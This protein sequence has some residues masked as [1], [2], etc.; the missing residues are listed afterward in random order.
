MGIYVT[1]DGGET[2]K[3][4]GAL[5]HSVYQIEEHPSDPERLAAACG[6]GG[7]FYT[8]NVG[9]WWE[10]ENSGMPENYDIRNIAI[11]DVEPQ[12]NRL[13]VYANSYG[14]G[15]FRSD[16][17]MSLE[18]PGNTRTGLSINS[19]YPNPAVNNFNME[20]NQESGE[21]CQISLVDVLGNV[22]AEFDE[23][24]FA[25]GENVLNLEL[26]SNIPAGMYLVRIKS[27]SGTATAKIN[28]G[29]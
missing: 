22:V 3:Y 25:E 20:W 4:S 19:V 7:V 28:I 10:V 1:R 9:L 2:W 14:T 24:Y 26:P 6:N 23:A 21:Y 12:G 29:K 17:L 8:D 18:E 5:G 13:T 27:N 15:I 11:P 16:L